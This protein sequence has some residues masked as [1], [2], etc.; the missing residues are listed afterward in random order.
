MK[1]L[2][3]VSRSLVTSLYEGILSDIDDQI[4]SNDKA[5]EDLLIFSGLFDICDFTLIDL[6]CIVDKSYFMELVDWNKVNKFTKNIGFRTSVLE[7]EYNRLYSLYSKELGIRG[8][9]KFK[10]FMIMLDNISLDS[11]PNKKMSSTFSDLF[12]EY[13]FNYKLK[14]KEFFKKGDDV[15]IVMGPKY[16]SKN[17]KSTKLIFTPNHDISKSSFFSILIKMKQPEL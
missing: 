17:S 7:N 5:V 1:S 14:I 8:I 4:V 11:L 9:K 15:L 6:K 3:N 10:Q 12:E 13:I 2:T 16:G